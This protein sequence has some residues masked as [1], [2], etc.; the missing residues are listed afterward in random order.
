[1]S[2]GAKQSRYIPEPEIAIPPPPPLPADIAIPKAIP[3]LLPSSAVG[4]E[5]IHVPFLLRTFEIAVSL[6]VLI[7]SSPILLLEALI[8]KLGTPGPALFLQTRMGGNY[9]HFKIVKFRTFYHDAKARFPE[10]YAYKFSDEE[11]DTYKIKG[12][13]DPR[14]T[15]Q[16]KWLRRLS[17]DELPNF[18]N[19]LVGDMSLVGP[20]PEIPEHLPYYKGEMRDKFT[21]RQGITGLAQISGRGRLTFLETA[22]YDVQYARTRSTLGDLKILFMTA[23]LILRDRGAF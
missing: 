21:V 1:M 16:G 23:W 14:I 22:R 7:V 19:V 5:P 18:W 6:F 9:K 8:I 4:L 17:I 2:A 20:R 3:A 11:I 12:E 10:M 15:P 13:D